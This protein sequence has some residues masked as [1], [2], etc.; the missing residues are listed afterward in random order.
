MY[1]VKAYFEPE[2]KVKTF[3]KTDTVPFF[4]GLNCL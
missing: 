2:M 3:H 4:I 1:F